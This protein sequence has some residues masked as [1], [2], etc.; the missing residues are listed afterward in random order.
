MTSVAPTRDPGL[1]RAVEGVAQAFHE[2]A[3]RWEQIHAGA[4]RRFAEGRVDEQRV[5]LAQRQ[6][7]SEQAIARAT[8]ALRGIPADAVIDATTLA[9]AVADRVEGAGR[10]RW[11]SDFA[12]ASWHRVRAEF[13]ERPEL[14]SSRSL[15]DGRGPGAWSVGGR[16]RELARALL[17]RLGRGLPLVDLW[18]DTA[19]LTDTLEG[20]CD[21]RG[22][23]E[24]R[25]FGQLLSATDQAFGLVVVTGPG[26]AAPLVLRFDRRGEGVR[27]AGVADSP[28]TCSRVLQMAAGLAADLSEPW[29]AVDYLARVAPWLGGSPATAA[30]GLPEL[31]AERLR[32]EFTAA[33]RDHG[34]CAAADEDGVDGLIRVPGLVARSPAPGV[35]PWFR[36]RNIVLDPAW[37]DAA[38]RERLAGVP[39][40]R[41]GPA[42]AFCLTL[43]IVWTGDVMDA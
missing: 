18:S 43:D 33:A 11:A 19:L 25:V 41:T 14:P 20:L 22:T 17:V 6:V 26:G 16:P 1:D 39:G 21:L 28:R 10:Q 38:A 24:L 42:G 12:R 4:L 31:G 29:L 15:P 36:V 2:H 40:R 27:L 3:R 30:L 23:L 7:S 34:I 32:R 8:R 5:A 13:A 9:G 35:A 37:C